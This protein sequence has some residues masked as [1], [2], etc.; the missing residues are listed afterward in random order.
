M[1]WIF[2]GKYYDLRKFYMIHP[3]G[4][5]YL[6]KT[7]NTDITTLTH[8]HHNNVPRIRQI[9]QSYEIPNQPVN[10]HKSTTF[11]K[12]SFYDDLKTELIKNNILNRHLD[13]KFNTLAVISL[14]T[15]IMVSGIACV[16]NSFPLIFISG[17][18]LSICGGFGH[19]YNH[20]NKYKWGELLFDLT[21]LSSVEWKIE[22]NIIHHVNVNNELDP[23]VTNFIPLFRFNQPYQQIITPFIFIKNILCFIVGTSSAILYVHFYNLL[24]R[25]K[26]FFPR[27]LLPE[28]FLLYLYVINPVNCLYVWFQ[29]YVY[30]SFWFLATEGLPAHNNITNWEKKETDWVLHTMSSTSDL[31]P[32]ANLFWKIISLFN[33]TH[34]IHHL[35]PL[36]NPLYT[37]IMYDILYEVCEKHGIPINNQ[38]MGFY[39]YYTGF[40]EVLKQCTHA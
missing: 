20:Y 36:V 28:L 2:E 39:N 27:Y 6:E 12:G 7:T 31:Y 1:Y 18:L 10:S 14:C 9:L 30:G 23:Y 17:I 38:N 13:T 33:N 25:Q 19:I 40:L 5:M 11:D 37:N 35:F 15:F 29:I 22:H 16:Y 26:M 34:T 4:K 21:G 8:I 3:G 24:I 32:R